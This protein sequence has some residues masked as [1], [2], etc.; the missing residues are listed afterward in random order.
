[1]ASNKKSGKAAEA[2]KSNAGI[3]SEFQIL[4]NEQR[5]MANK[6]S[7]ME[8]ELNEH[9]IVIDTLKNVDPKRKCFKMTGGVLC[10][11]TVQ[12]V[13]PALVTNKEQLIKV[14]DALN[15]QLTK[16]GVLI[17][18][19]KEKHNIRIR[20]QHDVQRPAGEDKEDKEAKRSAV[21]VN[22]L[23]NNYA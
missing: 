20:G 15:D 11:L 7:E 8:M 21:V 12:D 23:L 3:L 4:R 22:P 16:K 17:N 14:I 2:A 1:M 9:K 13:M 10:E 19:F 18:E 5:A 6:L